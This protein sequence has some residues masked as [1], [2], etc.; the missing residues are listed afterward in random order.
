MSEA[1]DS[2]APG[3]DCRGVNSTGWN[4]PQVSLELCIVTSTPGNANA[5]GLPQ[6]QLEKYH[7]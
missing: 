3:P 2:E 6:T 1:A 5:E 4:Y 7:C